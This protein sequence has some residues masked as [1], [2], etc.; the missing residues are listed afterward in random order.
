MAADSNRW[1][2][3]RVVRGFGGDTAFVP[4]PLT[5]P[6]TWDGELVAPLSNADRAIGRLA[7]EGWRFPDP[8]I[9][10]D[11][12]LKWSEVHS[13]RRSRTLP[14]GVRFGTALIRAMTPERCFSGL[15]WPT[16]G[17]RERSP[18]R[19][20]RYFAAGSMGPDRDDVAVTIIEVP[21]PKKNEWAE[22]QLRP[23]RF[24]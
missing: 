15:G 5:P 7:G 24:P 2:H 10:G 12:I 11:Y 13:T 18:P 16:T 22:V 8:E 19:R 17:N 3:G 21:P 9:F 1:P 23:H 20:R 6:L 14:G 4:V